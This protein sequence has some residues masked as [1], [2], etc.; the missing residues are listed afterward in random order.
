MTIY[1]ASSIN[2]PIQII[3]QWTEPTEKI[4]MM[5]FRSWPK[6]SATLLKKTS[7]YLKG[8]YMLLYHTFS[9]NMPPMIS[10]T[11]V[12]INC[13]II[14]E[15][16]IT[17]TKICLQSQ[18]KISC[19]VHF[20]LLCWSL[21]RYG[22]T[23]ASTKLFVINYRFYQEWNNIQLVELFDQ[24]FSNYFVWISQQF[25]FKKIQVSKEYLEKHLKVHQ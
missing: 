25:H 13:F 6:E 15:L 16:L 11:S 20:S 24:S 8:D 9:L 12:Y 4:P 23:V 21:R 22:L 19:N 10:Y 5:H 7:N 2:C 18:Y 3:T 14:G 17:Y 1:I